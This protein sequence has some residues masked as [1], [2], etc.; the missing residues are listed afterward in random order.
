MCWSPNAFANSLRPTPSNHLSEH[1]LTPSNAVSATCLLNGKIPNAMFE[2]P[3]GLQ[4]LVE[5]T[6]TDNFVQ[7]VVAGTDSPDKNDPHVSGT[8]PTSA[9]LL[10]NLEVNISVGF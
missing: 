5:F 9:V 7:R 4:K 6:L 2:V 3:N 1:P 10:P 8:L